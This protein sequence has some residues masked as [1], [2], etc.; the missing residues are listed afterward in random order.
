M[1]IYVRLASGRTITLI[2]NPFE[3]IYNIKLIIQEKEGI[4]PDQ[5]RLIFAGKQMEDNKTLNDYNIKKDSSIHELRRLKGGGVSYRK[6]INI[7]F[8]KDQNYWNI[9]PLK[10][11]FYLNNELFGLLKLCLLK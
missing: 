1:Q 6:E 4:P 11:S 2:V 9:S 8:I 5:Q 3:L 10:N 7:K